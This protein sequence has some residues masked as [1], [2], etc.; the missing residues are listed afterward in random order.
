MTFCRD[1]DISV[2]KEMTV[3]IVVDCR[4]ITGEVIVKQ[5][6]PV[7]RKLGWMTCGHGTYCAR[8][9]KFGTNIEPFPH[10][11][12]VEMANDFR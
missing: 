7:E 10:F 6:V 11:A 5:D 2:E 8:V 9:H 4:H 3:G 12:T 1:T